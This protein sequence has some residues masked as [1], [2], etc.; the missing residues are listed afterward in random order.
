[1]NSQER[2]NTAVL[3][4]MIPNLKHPE[5][6]GFFSKI[7][8]WEKNVLKGIVP[9]LLGINQ[10]NHGPL[11]NLLYK[12]HDIFPGQ[13]PKRVLKRKLGDI[14]SILLEPGTELV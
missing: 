7:F 12:Y 10:E 4:G 5:A 14:H 3:L 1:M 2:H 8:V 9:H 13:L 6:M 11:C